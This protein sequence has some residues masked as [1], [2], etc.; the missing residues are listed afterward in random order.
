MKKN[1][2]LDAYPYLQV[3]VLFAGIGSLVG[4]LVAQLFLLVIFRDADFA[5]IGYQPLLYVGL[6]GFIPALLTGMIVASQH[7]WRGDRKSLRTTFLF[8]FATSACYMGAIVLY[9][10]INSLIEIG[11]L[12]AFM[13][14]IG[15]FGAIN[16]AIASCIALP[17]VCK[18]RFDIKAK[19]E[20]DNYN[21]LRFT[22]K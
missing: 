1:N 6:L 7:I 8:G 17:K 18:S 4:G 3:V 11:V 5:Q 13:V 20:D 12:L 19:K 21:G 22:E 14:A 15:L 16:S 9:L 10:G 2:E